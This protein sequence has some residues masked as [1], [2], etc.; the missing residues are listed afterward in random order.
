MATKHQLGNLLV[1]AGIITMKTLERALLMQ[2]GSGKRLGLLLRELG[3]VTEDEIVEALARQCSLR[4]ARN[5]ADHAFPKELLD[6]VPSQ[7]ALERMIFPLKHFQD[8]LALAMTDPFDHATI[9]QLEVSSG[10][11]V[12]PAIA[13]ER[14]VFAAIQKHYLRK[15]VAHGGRQKILLLDGSEIVTQLLLPRLQRDGYEVMASNDGVDGLKLAFANHPDLIVCDLMMPSMDAYSFLRALRANQET[16]STPVMLM[17]SKTS[18]AEEH[19]ALQS[20]FIDLIAK[21]VMPARLLARIKRAM[22][23]QQDSRIATPPGV[24][25][26]PRYGAPSFVRRLWKG[27]GN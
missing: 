20:G 11:K 6:L 5:F 12:Y 23:L 24:A 10:L 14:D 4:V 21:P 3:V 8:M 18:D 9:K 2:Q 1:E 26:A 17:S 13:A 27:Q 25:P 22:A 15:K 7:L 19:K 16:A